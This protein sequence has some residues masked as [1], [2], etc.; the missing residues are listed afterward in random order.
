MRVW[1]TISG[2]Q[3]SLPFFLVMI[4]CGWLAPYFPSYSVRMS[5]LCFFPFMMTS[6]STRADGSVRPRSVLASADATLILSEGTRVVSVL[7]SVGGHSDGIGCGVWLLRRTRLLWTLAAIC[8]SN[9]I[10]CPCSLGKVAWWVV[11]EHFLLVTRTNE[12]Y[13]RLFSDWQYCI[14]CD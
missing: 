8:C 4:E 7:R 10:V 1:F 2:L 3:D 13:R 12:V 5:N 14:Y 6:S 11:L 9:E